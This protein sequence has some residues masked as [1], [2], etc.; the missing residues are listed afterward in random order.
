MT[1]EEKKRG[2]GRP[3]VKTMPTPIPYTPENVAKA[4]L[5]LPP[6]TWDYLKGSRMS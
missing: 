1:E 3:P 5:T 2:V 6:K 4:L